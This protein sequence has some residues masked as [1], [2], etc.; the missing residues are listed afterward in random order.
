[1]KRR[2][3]TLIELLT[4]CQDISTQEATS[5]SLPGLRGRRTGSHQETTESRVLD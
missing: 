3:F 2:A 1:M 4:V 5:R